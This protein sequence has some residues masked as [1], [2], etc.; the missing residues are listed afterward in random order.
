MGWKCDFWARQESGVGEG[1][2]RA[3]WF[4]VD[5]AWGDLKVLVSASFQNREALLF[6]SREIPIQI[7]AKPA[8]PHKQSRR[9]ALPSLSLLRQVYVRTITTSSLFITHSSRHHL[10][11]PGSCLPLLCILH[12]L[13]WSRLA[14]ILGLTDQISDLQQSATAQTTSTCIRLSSN[15]LPT[16]SEGCP[17]LVTSIVTQSSQRPSEGKIATRF[18]CSRRQSCISI[19]PKEAV[20]HLSNYPP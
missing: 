6:P 17:S 16:S 3:K 1:C 9:I 20:L 11:V 18:G 13:L 14:R 2:V 12:Q 8:R 15:R 10:G 19:H 4:C 5:T 7:P